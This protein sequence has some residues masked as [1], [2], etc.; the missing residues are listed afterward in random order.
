M[1]EEEKRTKKQKIEDNRRLRA[2]SQNV[3]MFSST[4]S[5]SPST[6][7]E[8]ERFNFPAEYRKIFSNDDS[9]SD[10]DNIT[11]QLVDDPNDIKDL[12]SL[13]DIFNNNDNSNTNHFDYKTLLKEGDRQLLTKI[14]HSYNLAV[15]LNTSVT[16]DSN[17]QC[18]R[19]LNN[20]TNVINELTQMSTL[21]TITFLKL[22]PEF[23]VRM[24]SRE[25]K[26]QYP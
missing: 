4:P 23:N 8:T 19:N 1:S 18:I 21:R 26:P 14:D 5:S 7:P 17:S 22:I 3:T 12:F 9:D 11:A 10:S 16:K 25:N 24:V 15:Q 2:M 20:V 13:E 6:V